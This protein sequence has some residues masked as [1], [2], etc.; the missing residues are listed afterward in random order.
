MTSA[1]LSSKLITAIL[2][3]GVALAVIKKYRDDKNIITANMNFARAT[4]NLTPLK[5]R[6]EV[7]EREK[8][9]LIIE[10]SLWKI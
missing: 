7:V 1:L 6:D 8:E 4:G 2:P 3:K 10:T 5:Y 9:I